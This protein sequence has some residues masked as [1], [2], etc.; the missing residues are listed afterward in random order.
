ML[1]LLQVPDS[2]LKLKLL[3][4]VSGENDVN[5]YFHKW[6]VS[7][8]FSHH[9]T[10]IISSLSLS[11]SLSS[12]S[13]ART[14][15][16]TLFVSLSFT[17]E[18]KMAFL[19]KNSSRTGCGFVLLLFLRW[20]IKLKGLLTL[21]MKHFSVS[22][23]RV[24]AQAVEQWLSVQAG[25]VQILCCVNLRLNFLHRIRSGISQSCH[26]CRVGC[27]FNTENLKKFDMVPKVFGI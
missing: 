24:E 23:L 5:S 27:F 26:N 11:L 25:R 22:L 4:P 1:L 2:N 17:K 3:Q 6:D 20:S 10:T 8:Y 16:H 18:M 19:S 13:F 15:T 7:S 14:L 12:S 9:S 21:F